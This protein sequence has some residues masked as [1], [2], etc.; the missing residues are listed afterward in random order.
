MTGPS[1][2]QQDSLP[3]EAEASPAV[4][5]A[6]DHFDP[7]DVA[8]DH[9]GAPRQCEASGDGYEIA[10]EA[11]DIG[12]EAGQVVGA[13]RLDPLRELVA[14][15]LGEHFPERTDVPGEGIQFGATGEDGFELQA[16]ARPCTTGRGLGP[17]AGYLDAVQPILGGLNSPVAR[18]L[19][20]AAPTPARAARLTRTQLR[21]VLKRAGRQRGIEDEVTRLHAALRVPQ[22]RQLPLVEDAIGRQALTLLRKLD[23]ACISADEL[24]EAAVEA[25]E[26]HPDAGIITSFPGLGSL[27]GARVLAEIGDDRSRFADAK[28]LKAYA[29]R[30]L[31]RNHCVPHPARTFPRDCGLTP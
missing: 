1:G 25:F 16:L 22:M 27:T 31:R 30:P 19:L 11:V 13:D 7:V 26:A 29:G 21:S 3:Q 23:T 8:F 15:E 2:R 5:L 6:L 20:A 4:H 9:A 12:V 24:A 10:F 18:V 28:G 17:H 14:L